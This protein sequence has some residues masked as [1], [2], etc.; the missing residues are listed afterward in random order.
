MKTTAS[1]KSTL[2]T[3]FKV[4][5]IL[6]EAKALE[7]KGNNIVHFEVGEPDFKSPKA[8]NQAGIDAIK[9]NFTK[10]THSLG[11]P[12]LRK[13]ITRF[14]KKEYGVK[15]DEEQVIVSNGSSAGL[16]LAFASIL[17]R[18]DNVILGTP[19]Y[20]CYPNYIKFL[21]GQPRFVKLT[22]KEN[23]QLLPEKVKK[24]ITKKTVAILINSPSNPTGAVLSPV[25]MA[26]IANLGKLIV[27]DEIYHGITYGKKAHSI[28]EFTKD[29]FVL[30]GF[31]KRFAMTGW[32]IG[33]A[34]APKKFMRAMQKVQQSFQ[35]SANSIAQK[36]AIAALKSPKKE[37]NEMKKSY[38][39][40]RDLMVDGLKSA[41]FTITTPPDGAFYV[42]AS[43]RFLSR[44][45]MALAKEI[46]YKAL[47]AVT[48]GIDFGS[49]GEG[50]LRFSYTTCEKNILEGVKRLKTFIDKHNLK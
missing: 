42:F 34:I 37:I 22:E 12:E 30:G 38:H 49:A 19:H 25:N 39:K 16:F 36:A 35:I 14:Y 31:S 28:L 1:K 24:K 43:A 15:V 45:S 8:V 7:A 5:D 32:R 10:Y 44:D 48:P 6:E 50:F 23:F 3:S 2:M 21:G 40:R 17:D 20:S 29:A 13:E 46:L 11:V 27:S 18:G 9:S 33:Y 4:M 26:E 41:G 47:V